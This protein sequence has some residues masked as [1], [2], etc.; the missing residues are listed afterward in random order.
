MAG[1]NFRCKNVRREDAPT[2]LWLSTKHVQ[3]YIQEK[4][5]VVVATLRKSHPEYANLGNI[6][7]QVCGAKAS[8]KFVPL[9][10][11]LPPAALQDEAT[12]DDSVPTIFKER[13][14]EGQLTLI[15]ALEKL[16]K[17]WAYTKED[18]KE[19]LRNT[20]YQQRVLNINNR[21]AQNII[22]WSVPRYRE[23]KD[24][25]ERSELI[26][27]FIDPISIFHEMVSEVNETKNFT[28]E[29]SDFK[30][31][32]HGEYEFRIVKS[33]GKNKKNKKGKS[34]LTQDIDSFLRRG[35]NI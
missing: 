6:Q 12:T 26:M 14:E 13:D 28:V 35:G 1:N 33:Y 10:I 22:N 24:G 19:L 30:K 17:L 31:I 21:T 20:T 2:V 29:I 18:K 32:R 4:V 23:R 3:E 5:D 11:I 7:I 34:S 9:M 16:F 27:F 8:E 25:D 15:P